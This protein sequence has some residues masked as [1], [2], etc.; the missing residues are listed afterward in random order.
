MMEGTAQEAS[1][2]RQSVSK[3]SGGACPDAS[4]LVLLPSVTFEASAIVLLSDDSFWLLLVF[5]TTK[6]SE[7]RAGIEPTKIAKSVESMKGE[8]ASLS[9]QSRAP[10]PLLATNA[11]KRRP[12]L[13]PAMD[14][15]THISIRRQMKRKERE[16]E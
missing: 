12:R 1:I 16:R 3:L 7:A 10:P 5:S 11:R 15:T 14:K 9:S 4:T 8:E 6:K 13:G 2:L